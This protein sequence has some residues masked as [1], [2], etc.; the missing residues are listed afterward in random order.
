MNLEEFRVA[1]A[2]AREE[3]PQW[4]GL[5]PD[6]RP[7]DARIESQQQALGVRLPDEYVDF[8]REFGGGDFAF[9]AVYSMDENSDVNVVV[10]NREPWL[11]RGDFVAVADNGAGDYYGFAVKDGRCSPQVLLLDHETGEMRAIGH[12]DFFEFAQAE[13]LQQ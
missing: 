6:A 1:V 2:R 9:L 8:V 13:G 3:H 11:N 7:D 5:P 4:F 12:A 10:K